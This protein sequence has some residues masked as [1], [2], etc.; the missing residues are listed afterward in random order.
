MSLSSPLSL[1][2]SLSQLGFFSSGTGLSQPGGSAKA[3]AAASI[4][5]TSPTTDASNIIFFIYSF[6]LSLSVCDPGLG[7]GRASSRPPAPRPE[8][9]SLLLLGTLPWPAALC[10]FRRA[11]RGGLRRAYSPSSSSSALGRLRPCANEKNRGEINPQRRL[12]GSLQGPEQRRT[13]L[14][15]LARDEVGLEVA[16]DQDRGE[17]GQDAHQQR[18]YASTGQLA[19]CP[20]E[21]GEQTLTQG[22]H[23]GSHWILRRAIR[24]RLLRLAGSVATTRGGA[25]RA[26]GEGSKDLCGGARHARRRVRRALDGSDSAVQRARRPGTQARRETQRLSHRRSG[27]DGRGDEGSGRLVVGERRKRTTICQRGDWCGDRFGGWFGHEPSHE[28]SE[29]FRGRR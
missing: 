12:A 1:S 10:P 7:S 3:G 16:S 8:N 5:A 4:R 17:E 2:R 11:G 19:C 18:R 25:G 26:A 9:S 24:G 6:S 14:R 22:R 13:W 15:H 23:K 27:G 21:G 28:C 29:A 20:R